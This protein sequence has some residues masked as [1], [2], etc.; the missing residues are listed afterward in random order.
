[1]NDN[2]WTKKRI[3][4]IC[5]FGILAIALII[6]RLIGNKAKNEINIVTSSSKFYTVSN[7]VYRYL[8]YVNAQD[9]ESVIKLLDNSYKE[10]EKITKD[11]VFEKI[12]VYENAYTFEA[13][14]MYQEK[15]NKDI[16]KYYVYGYLRENTLDADFTNTH[17]DYYIIVI[18]NTKNKTFSIIPYKG[19]IFINGGNK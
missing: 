17:L 3:I 12:T 15:V 9:G 10:K 13:R 8:T 11:N 16:T 5:F 18:L 19:D 4:I 7:C 14:K 1:M 6:F 2:I